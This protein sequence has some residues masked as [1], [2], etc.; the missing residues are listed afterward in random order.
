MNTNEKTSHKI[1]TFINGFILRVLLTPLKSVSLF[2][3]LGL[4]LCEEGLRRVGKLLVYSR[5]EP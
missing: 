5:S 1:H 4:G 2:A 3:L